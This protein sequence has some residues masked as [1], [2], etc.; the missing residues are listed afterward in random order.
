MRTSGAACP[1]CRQQGYE[2]SVKNFKTVI[3]PTKSQ[4]AFYYHHEPAILHNV[5]KYFSLPGQ[6]TTPM[7]HPWDTTA[8]IKTL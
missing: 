8:P 7:A 2:M 1:E 4:F 3:K 5:I 6:T